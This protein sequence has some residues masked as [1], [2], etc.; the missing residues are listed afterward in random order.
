[1]KTVFDPQVREELIARV[2]LLSEQSKAEWGKMNV[3]QMMKHC[4]KGN[5]MLFGSLKVKRVFIGR[6]I[7]RFILKV[8]LKDEK[9]LKKN[10]PTAVE[11]M[12]SENSGDFLKTKAELL[13]GIKAYE[14][15]KVNSF[16][17]P[18][19]GLMNKDEIGQ[20]AYK[21][22]DHHLRQFGV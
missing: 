19:F 20:L 4:T 22:N 21:H 3:V 16:I 9:P 14:F 12:V 8:V 17:H 10:S 11:L 6:L 18:F 2:N 13:N 7:G 5:E 15:I 1:M